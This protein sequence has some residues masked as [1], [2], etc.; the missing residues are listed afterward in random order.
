M[1]LVDT[2][3]AIFT[4]LTAIES[5]LRNL[6]SQTDDA[7]EGA[8]SSARLTQSLEC[9]MQHLTVLLLSTIACAV[10]ERKYRLKTNALL[11]Q[12]KKFNSTLTLWF[13]FVDTLPRTDSPQ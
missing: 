11:G 10:A 12:S 9:I 2:L 5:K 4:Q 7:S 6:T 13:E 8:V 1:T 3:P